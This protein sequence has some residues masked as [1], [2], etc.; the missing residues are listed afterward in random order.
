MIRSPSAALR[1]RELRARLPIREAVGARFALEHQIAGSVAPEA[2]LPVG[3]WLVVRSLRDPQPRALSCRHD[4]VMAPAAWQSAFRGRLEQM[5]AAAGRPINGVILGDTEAVLFRHLGELLACLAQS[6]R[7]GRVGQEWWW[8]SLL[9]ELRPESW[10]DAWTFHA[11]AIPSALSQLAAHAALESA[12]APLPSR[13]TSALIAALVQRFQLDPCLLPDSPMNA[14]LHSALGSVPQVDSPAHESASTAA[15]FPSPPA[16]GTEEIPQEPFSSGRE[17]TPVSSELTALLPEV[18]GSGWSRSALAVVAIGLIL[19]RAP[20]RVRAAEF[21]AQMAQWMEAIRLVEPITEPP[22]R[23]QNSPKATTVSRTETPPPGAEFILQSETTR[24]EATRTAE[25]DFA[26]SESPALDTAIVHNLPT[27]AE[28][29]NS[30]SEFSG[31]ATRADGGQDW[32]RDVVVREEFATA[33]GG[34]FYLT[35]VAL[36]LGLYGDFT[37]PRRPGIELPFW[38]FLAVIGDRVLGPAFRADPLWESLALWSGREPS[39]PPGGRFIPPA[40]WSLEASWL[41]PFQESPAISWLWAKGQLR[42]W[43]DAGFVVLDRACASA[44]AAET[45]VLRWLPEGWTAKRLMDPRLTGPVAPRDPAESATARQRR[46]LRRWLARLLPYLQ[47]RLRR[48]LPSL[49][50]EHLLRSVL[51]QP[52]RICCSPTEVVVQFPLVSHPLA[53]RM[54]GLDRDPG[55][56]PAAGRSISFVYD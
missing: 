1:I 2:I 5:L 23:P 21:G 8:R 16:V 18:A 51:R 52:G 22:R 29:R 37:Q 25:E 12:L 35:N 56:V 50:E 54:A 28:A 47:A 38:D 43:H 39:E 14:W 27:A 9:G 41:V 10:V 44:D 36:A 6:W 15:T 11:E 30:E 7:A 45:E 17:S 31:A 19:E 33:A 55:W 4:R 13:E 34:L 32:I 24:R 46:A 40:D 49:N 20:Q 3:A 26:K 53:I 48:A 42:A